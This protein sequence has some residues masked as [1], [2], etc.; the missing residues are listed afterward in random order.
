MDAGRGWGRTGAALL[1]TAWCL[2]F[3]PVL[4]VAAQ[5]ASPVSPATGHAEV[6]AQ[7]LAEFPQEQVV[8]RVAYHSAE[9]GQVVEAQA[10]APG[11]ALAD[12][13]YLLTGGSGHPAALAPGE[14]S[15]FSPGNDVQ[16]LAAGTDAAT[17]YTI[18]LATAPG[19]G[20]GE[21]RDGT[22]VF[23]SAPFAAPAGTRDLDLVRDTLGPGESATI[24]GGDQ[25]TLVLATIGEV[26]ARASD[27]ALAPLKVGQAAVFTG[28]VDITGGGGAPSAF[29]AAV[30]GPELPGVEVSGGVSAPAPPA[31]T[32]GAVEVAPLAT[33]V[34]SPQAA[35]AGLTL[36]LDVY[37]CP[38]GTK[39]DQVGQERCASTPDAGTFTLL[40]VSDLGVRDLGDPTAETGD[41]LPAWS[42]L[43]PGGYV[44]QARAFAA[45]KDR[46]VVPEQGPF[47][48]SPT[49]GYGASTDEGYPVIL[50]AGAQPPV[51][52]LYVLA[53]GAGT[54]AQAQSTPPGT[55]SVIEVADPKSLVRSTAVATPKRGSIGVRVWSCPASS[56]AAF[57]PAAC[58][59]ASPPFDVELSGG[60][61]DAP[62][63]LAG[64]RAN[65]DGAF[66]WRDLGFGQYVLRHPLLAPGSASYYVVGP[67]VG[68]LPDATG[69]TVVID[70][71]AP[72]TVL[73]VYD[74]AAPP[75]AAPT[76][77]PAVAVPTPVPAAAPPPAPVD[78]DGDG[79]T[80]DVEATLGTNPALW[81]TDGDGISDGVEVS[82]GTD[83]LTPD[84]AP[85]PAPP[86]NSGATGDA[87]GQP[88]AVD[89]DGDG[90]TDDVEA[91]IGTDPNVW[92]T[93]GDGWSDGDEQNLGTNPLDPASHPVG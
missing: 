48:A 56:L 32:P 23:L 59:V 65:G 15:F 44:L 37:A 30:I 85:T 76:P 33:P 20:P 61:L 73:D 18:E 55:G 70:A 86:A 36:A 89:S 91:T 54:T 80:D 87:G 34:A 63:T 11:W 1:V 50:A 42:G 93:D 17:W 26:R 43:E 16:R 66:V 6:V 31:A 14:A 83:P 60:G 28:D 35:T 51:L 72:T 49:D 19:D 74:L 8:W 52:R 25:P 53:D 40:A 77:V 67:T 13:G 57:D 5:D 58:V 3:G 7:G 45:G 62:R 79:L 41:G 39:P 71:S 2:A 22:P 21:G 88:G 12:G 46:F 78:S 27:G 10:T 47:R 84:A 64:L 24:R 69:Y 81:D 9:P 68:L 90:L 29:V 38:A 75:P 82:Q 4:G 92:D